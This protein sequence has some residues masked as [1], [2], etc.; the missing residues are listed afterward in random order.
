MELKLTAAELA[1]QQEIRD[2]VRT[3]QPPEIRDKLVTGK[4]LTPEDIGTWQ[5]ILDDRGWAAPH[6]PEEWGGCGWDEI[7]RAHV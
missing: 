6:W 4:P 7:G 1:L 3:A 2:F 5:R